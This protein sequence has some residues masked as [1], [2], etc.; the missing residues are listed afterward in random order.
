MARIANA[1]ESCSDSVIRVLYF[2]N[3]ISVAPADKMP[4]Q[5][6]RQSKRCRT[7]QTR[8]RNN[9]SNR[10]KQRDSLKD[11]FFNHTGSTEDSCSLAPSIVDSLQDTISL[12][13]SV[14]QDFFQNLLDQVPE[15]DEPSEAGE[16]GD[17]H[18][19]IASDVKDERCVGD[20]TIS[21]LLPAMNIDDNKVRDDKRFGLSRESPSSMYRS[22]PAPA[23]HDRPK[24]SWSDDE[25]GEEN[26]LSRDLNCQFRRN[27]SHFL[28]EDSESPDERDPRTHQTSRHLRR[29]PYTPRSFSKPAVHDYNRRALQH[30]I[31]YGAP[32][33]EKSHRDELSP[34]M[35]DHHNISHNS[36][37]DGIHRSHQSARDT[38]TR[39]HGGVRSS[40]GRR[41]YPKSSQQ[42][43]NR[44]T[45]RN[46]DQSGSGIK[47]RRTE[48]PRL[49]E[50]GLGDVVWRQSLA[51][52]YALT[53]HPSDRHKCLAT[54]NA[55]V[56]LALHRTADAM[57]A[58][59][60]SFGESAKRQVNVWVEA[61]SDIVLQRLEFEESVI[62]IIREIFHPA[63]GPYVPPSRRQSLSLLQPPIDCTRNSSPIT[64]T[65]SQHVSENEKVAPK[66]K[67]QNSDL[68]GGIDSDNP[69]SFFGGDNGAGSH[70]RVCTEKVPSS[71]KIAVH[72]A[73][74]GNTYAENVELDKNEKETQVDEVD[75]IKDNGPEENGYLTPQRER[76]VK[77]YGE[78]SSEAG[79]SGISL[80]HM[81]SPKLKR[82]NFDWLSTSNPTPAYHGVTDR[83]T[84]ETV[85]PV[86]EDS[87]YEEEIDRAF[88]TGVETS[89]TKNMTRSRRRRSKRDSDNIKDKDQ[90]EREVG[91]K[92]TTP[93]RFVA[94]RLGK[95]NKGFELLRRLGWDED[96]GLGAEKDGRLDP[97]EHERR[98]TRRHGIG[99]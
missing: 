24:M 25:S 74:E 99:L 22:T 15:P 85:G 77:L 34:D 97:V 69:K 39:A 96:Q 61:P 60:Q 80:L 37:Y 41:D 18:T 17:T 27:S 95:E 98:Q 2:L 83:G 29:A 84:I 75:V 65:T 12:P 35:R 62:D 11:I 72:T 78:L 9:G 53:S 67:N 5:R 10:C 33:Y 8:H 59:S 4:R 14:C 42:Q 7:V 68:V 76:R 44:R 93:T 20:E 52:Y 58:K 47:F 40:R 90:G 45:S 73:D 92:E 38:R 63:E 31:H 94:R 48:T 57:G 3:S 66:L 55:R 36:P 81:S 21:E 91:E 56:R 87:E 86:A 49:G 32:T 43:R 28:A 50:R 79:R 64:K 19:P 23:V 82:G 26:V 30:D 13:S 46:R 51:L 71:S 1:P 6:K 54:D 16:A 70:D 89:S 88:S